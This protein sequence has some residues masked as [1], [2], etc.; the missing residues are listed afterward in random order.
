VE[1]IEERDGE[2]VFCYSDEDTREVKP[3]R[4]MPPEEAF[5]RLQNVLEC[6]WYQIHHV[7]LVVEDLFCSRK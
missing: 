6:L 7:Q 1:W 5:A 4:E 3:F 2:L